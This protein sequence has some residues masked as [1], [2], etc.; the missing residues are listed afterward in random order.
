MTNQYK[1]LVDKLVF[2]RRKFYLY[3]LYKGIVFSIVLLIFYY[4][5]VSAYEYFNYSSVFFR[6]SLFIFTLLFIL[7]LSIWFVFI[8][9]LKLIGLLKPIS[10]KKA[11]IIIS[12]HFGEIEDKLFNIIELAEENSY[13]NELVWASID[14]KISKIRLLNFTEVI[15]KNKLRKLFYLLVFSFV[16]CTALYFTFPGLYYESTVRIINFNKVFFKPAPFTF[17]LL[18]ENLSVQKGKSIELTVL[19]EGREVPD[20]LY[21]SI[22]GNKFLMS[23]ENEYFT[24]KLDQVHNNLSFFFTDLNYVSNNYKLTILPNPSILNYSVQISPPVYTKHA[25][26][27]LKNIGDLQIPYG[28]QLKWIFKVID[29]DSLKVSFNNDEIF[30]KYEEDEIFVEHLITNDESYSVSLKNKHFTIEDILNFNIEVISDLYPDINVVQLRDSTNYSRFYFK[31]T[32]LDDYGFSGLTFNMN[33]NQKDSANTLHILNNLNEQD[34]YFTFDFKDVENLGSDITYYFTVSDNDYFHNNKKTTSEVFQFNFPSKK[35]LLLSDNQLFSDIQS[36]VEKSLE[37]SNKL[38]ESIEELK[39]KSIS[40]DI[41]DW[42]KQ[43]LMNEIIDKKTQLENVLDQV[44]KQNSEMNSMMNS[45]TDE[46]EE[47]LKQQ[48]QIEELL[49]EVMNDELKAL[50]EEFNKLAEEFDQSKFNELIDDNEMSLEDLSQQLER[51]L[52]MLKRMKIEQKIEKVIQILEETY[53]NENVNLFELENSDILDDIKSKEKENKELL[54]VLKDEMK[55]VNELNE[56]LEKPMNLFSVEKE[57]EEIIEKYTST[58][59]WLDKNRRKKAEDNIEDNIDLIKNLSFSLIQMLLN[60]NKQQNTENIQNLKQILD[61]LIYMSVNQENVMVL[62]VGTNMNDPSFNSIISYQNKLVDQ[63]E[64]VKDSLYALANRTPSI[65][66]KVNGELLKLD[67]SLGKSLD[68]LVEGNISSA[69]RFQQNSMTSINEMALFLN[70]SLENL[71]KQ[72]GGGDQESDKQGEGKSGMNM[73]KEAQQ[74]LKDQMQQMIEQMKNGD[75]KNLKQQIGK[76]L[77]QQEM[78]QQMISEMLNNSEVGSSAKEQ[79]KQME[80]LNEQNRVDLMNKSI[81]TTMINRQNLILDKLLKAEKS[82]MER[83]VEDERESKTADDEFYS[84]PVEFFEYKHGE[85]TIIEDIRYNNY[86]LRNYY[87]K[88]YREYINNLNN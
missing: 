65:S 31:G 26:E 50:F 18:N 68:E 72:M 46:K 41:S 39:Y 61:N 88:I 32:I 54:N 27:T 74:S 33:I 8:P 6:T 59:E 82:E 42:E 63:S 53:E 20:N 67:Y 55:L 11:S 38:E 36:L 66:S 4:S 56:S 52:Q 71:E 77:I 34:F 62:S 29:T 40:E 69:Q 1:Q 15:D 85:K 30:G 43:Q 3:Q 2:F 51:N 17:L 73:L 48:Q 22:G 12:N 81:T 37:L 60:N 58:I 21:V 10:F 76:S 28:T 84:N 78:I 83:D 24:Y 5:A 86:K 70:E 80:L 45:F 23:N 64:V 7:V 35:E 57:F 75:G 79:L 47:I 9:V 87:D 14:N 13:D 49:N 44:K 25:K 16:S 19:C